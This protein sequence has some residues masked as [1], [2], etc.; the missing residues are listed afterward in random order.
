MSWLQSCSGVLQGVPFTSKERSEF[1]IREGSDDDDE[2]IILAENPGPGTQ[3]LSSE[4][5]RSFSRQSTFSNFS[6][7]MV[8]NT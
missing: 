1:N 8:G 5:T 7:G 4:A 6:A 2:I 3:P